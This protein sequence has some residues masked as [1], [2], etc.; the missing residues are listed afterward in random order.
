MSSVNLWENVNKTFGDVSVELSRSKKCTMLF[1]LSL[2]EVNSYLVVNETYF[3]Q[4]KI[5]SGGDEM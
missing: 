2:D 4:I 1:S 3:L 5:C